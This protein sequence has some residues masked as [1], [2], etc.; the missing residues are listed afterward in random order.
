ME[1]NKLFLLYYMKT[2]FLKTEL[3]IDVIETLGGKNKWLMYR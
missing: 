3:H 2:C 1:G